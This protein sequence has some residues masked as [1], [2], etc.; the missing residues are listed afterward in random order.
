MG[1][2]KAPVKIHR[3]EKYALRGLNDDTKTFFLRNFGCA[4]K[5]YNLYVEFL[6][7]KLEQSGYKEGEKLPDIKIPEVT[8]FKKEYAYLK[9]ADSLGLANATIYFSAAMERYDKGY[10]HT[11]YTKRALRRDASGTEKLSFRGLRGMP[12]FHA[13]ACGYFSYTTNAQ[14]PDGKNGLKKPTVRIERGKLFLPKLRDGVRIVM[15]R[16]LPEGAVIGSVTVSMD[17]GGKFYAS[18][19]YE[20]TIWMDMT[21]RDAAL[22]G[23]TEAADGL[24]FIGLDYSQE[25]FYVDSS[26]RRAEPPHSYRKS[27]EKLALLQK[28]LSRM[29][30]GSSNY[31]KMKARIGKLHTKVK[32]QRRDFIMKEAD[33]LSREYDVV[34]VEDIDLRAMGQ[35][36][37]LGRN[38]HDNGFGMFRTQLAHKLERKGSVLVKVDRSFASTK[39]CSCCGVKGLDIKLGVK[40]WICPACGARHDRDHNA[41]VNIREEGKRIFAGYMK[42][43]LEEEAASRK[44]AEKRTQARRSGRK[45][46]AV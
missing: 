27:G 10:D 41:A 5:V 14:Y 25:H 22:S 43:H 24:S 39:T 9:E 42:R 44:R 26:G 18:V 28:K 34:C 8:A 30:K 15:H 1:A 7:E 6:Y 35:A 17:A 13:K 40:E 46:K 3:T 37:S 19:S 33:R 16:P 2:H 11:S 38:L 21:I 36:L 31:G 20:Y 12:K 45:K 4:R 23:G 29:G 32:D